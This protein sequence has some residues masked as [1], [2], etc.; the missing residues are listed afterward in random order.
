MR[1]WFIDQTEYLFEIFIPQFLL[2]SAFYA[3]FD[4]MQ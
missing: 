1:Q 2:K 3:V 4:A